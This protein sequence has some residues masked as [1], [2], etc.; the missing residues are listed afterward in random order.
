MDVRQLVGVTVVVLVLG[1]TT[2]AEAG[3]RHRHHSRHCTTP[4]SSGQWF[5]FSSG[6]GRYVPF[7]SATVA[8]PAYSQ[9]QPVPYRSGRV[10]QP[11]SGYRP[12]QP[13]CHGCSVR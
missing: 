6:G 9:P 12:Y 3:R 13:S 4:T 1:M 7:A 8:A 10:I 5:H 11:A 2:V